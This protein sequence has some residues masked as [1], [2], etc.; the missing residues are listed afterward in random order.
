[1]WSSS[2]EYVIFCL[3]YRID[4]SSSWL[5]FWSDFLNPQHHIILE[6]NCGMSSVFSCNIHIVSSNYFSYPEYVRPLVKDKCPVS[7]F[8]FRRKLPHTKTQQS[9]DKA[10]AHNG[11]T[12]FSQDLLL[13]MHTSTGVVSSPSYHLSS[14][15]YT[16]PLFAPTSLFDSTS[17]RVH[18]H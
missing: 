10:G 1:M 12:V 18:R 3:K 6:V 8:G 2:L 14:I 17:V 4:K 11:R 16:S 5:G 9:I 13:I 7:F 15:H